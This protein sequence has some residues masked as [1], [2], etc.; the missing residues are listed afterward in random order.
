[1]SVNMD[2][3]IEDNAQDSLLAFREWINNLNAGTEQEADEAAFIHLSDVPAT[4]GEMNQIADAD[5]PWTTVS[6][7]GGIGWHNTETGEVVYKKEDG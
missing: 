6:V 4:R 2:E 3:L 5:T 7:E 1:M